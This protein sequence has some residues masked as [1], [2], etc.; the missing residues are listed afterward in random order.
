MLQIQIQILIWIQDLNWIRILVWIQ[1]LI[2]IR[3]LYL[4]PDHYRDPDPYLDWPESA[5]FTYRPNRVLAL[6][7]PGSP[8]FEFHMR[9]KTS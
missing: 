5:S 3:I 8:M 2:W 7:A 6:V 1:M 4:D 9:K